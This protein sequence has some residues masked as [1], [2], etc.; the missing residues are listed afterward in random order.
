MLIDLGILLKGENYI[1]W[2]D[3]NVTEAVLNTKKSKDPFVNEEWKVIQSLL[4]LHHIDLSPRQV[5]SKENIANSLSR[6]I[7]AP[8][9]KETRVW[10]GI[11]DNL[12]P[13]IFHV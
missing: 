10:F 5:V 7:Q 11:P 2:T 4:M 1:V 3:N 12:V 8:H 6:G 13:F 9:I